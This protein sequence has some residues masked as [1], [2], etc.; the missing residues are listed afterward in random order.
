M[1]CITSTVN[2]YKNQH[3]KPT[4]AHNISIFRKYNFININVRLTLCNAICMY[5]RLVDP[6]PSF[7]G[8]ISQTTWGVLLKLCDFS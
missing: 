5:A 7:S 8:N 1:I 2:P 3:I 6:Q 4:K